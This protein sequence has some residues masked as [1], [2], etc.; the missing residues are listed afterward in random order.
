MKQQV[1]QIGK[2]E[3]LISALFRATKGKRVSSDSDASQPMHAQD[4]REFT[5][6]VHIMFDQM[7]Y[8]A[9]MCED[10]FLLL[11]FLAV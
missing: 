2:H 7:P 6:M 4:V 1:A 8:H 9:L 11:S 3:M 5:A 10:H